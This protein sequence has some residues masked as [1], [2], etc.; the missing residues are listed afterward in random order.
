MFQGAEAVDMAGKLLD[1]DRS[2]LDRRDHD[3]RTPLHVASLYGHTKLMTL[4]LSRG[5]RLLDVDTTNLTP[6]GIAI[7]SR[8]VFGTWLLSSWH[9]KQNVA[10]MAMAQRRK[11]FSPI[12]LRREIS[13]NGNYVSALEYLLTPGRH[14]PNQN[15]LIRQGM[16][17]FLSSGWSL[18]GCY[19]IPFSK[20]SLTIVDVL[21]ANYKQ[22]TR[23]IGTLDLLFT[24]QFYRYESGM[25]WAVR[26]SN[27]DVVQRILDT[28]SDG[29]PVFKTHLRDLIAIACRRPRN[30]MSLV[31]SL[32]QR[33]ALMA[34]LRQRQ[35]GEYLALRDKRIGQCQSPAL[36][37]KLWGFYYTVYGNMEQKQ[38][39][40]AVEWQLTVHHKTWWSDPRFLEFRQWHHP[41]LS[42]Y[43]VLLPLLWALVL[44]TILCYAIVARDPAS[45]MSSGN[46]ACAILAVI[47]VSSRP[48]SS[49]V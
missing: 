39:E 23:P 34:Y 7:R 4:F 36:R 47:L 1:D 37:N 17:E 19:D 14:T 43:A 44:P 15:D 24:Y 40:R 46:I 5:A 3:A 30:G 22:R 25:Q 18:L 6:L 12:D 2:N 8:H 28:T 42:I 16:I 33:K 9:R 31:G 35:T 11:T 10:L 48:V 45:D 21:L 27:L 32:K 49:Q 20:V 41:R 13:G 29:R 26:T 38:Y